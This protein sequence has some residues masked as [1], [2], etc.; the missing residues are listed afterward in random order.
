MSLSLMPT[1]R[2]WLAS[3]AA[4]VA[5]A[6]CGGGIYIG[7]G[8]D[9]D[10]APQV[11]LVA[12]TAVASPGQTITLLAAASDDYGVERVEFF[13]IEGNGNAVS[14]GFDGSAPYRFDTALPDTGAGTVRYFARA[15]DE[16]DQFND[17]GTFSVT[18]MR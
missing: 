14:L 8:G 18:V 12:S 11:S 10:R 16:G 7:F 9:D 1:R 4:C 13:R 6:G 5:L 3:F 15:F 17:S 2:R